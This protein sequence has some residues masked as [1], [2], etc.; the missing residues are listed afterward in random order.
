MVNKMNFNELMLVGL[1]F[2]Q[3]PR[4]EKVLPYLTV[5]ICFLKGGE[6]YGPSS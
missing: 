5:V 4:E 6:E 3:L 1:D 2:H